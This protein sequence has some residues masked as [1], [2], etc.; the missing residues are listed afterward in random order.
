M[1]IVFWD[2]KNLAT[3]GVGVWGVFILAFCICKTDGGGENVAGE[4]LGESFLNSCCLSCLQAEA[5]WVSISE[6]RKTAGKTK[7]YFVYKK[8]MI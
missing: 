5:E 7:M 2:A 3:R 1:H 6:R 8:K 4:T